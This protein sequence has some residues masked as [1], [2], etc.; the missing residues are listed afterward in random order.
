VQLKTILNRIEKQRFF[1]YGRMVLS[2]DKGR[3]V[4]DVD[5]LPRANSKPFCSGCMRRRPVYDHLEARRFEFVP[6]W[7]IAVFFIYVM[8]RVNCRTCGIIV[9]AVPWATGKRQITTSYAWFLARWAKR[10]SWLEVARTF[11]TTWEHVFRSVEMA[12]GWGRQHMNLDGIR[13]IGIDEI[14]WRK[15]HEYLTV[16]YQIDEGVRRLLWVGQK[17]TAK[18]LLRF[19][20]WF[21]KERTADLTFICSDMW[22]PYLKVIAK[23]ASQALNILDRFHIMS[24]MSKAIDEIRAGEARE[25]MRNGNALLKGSRWW[26]LKRPENLKA[27]QEASLREL[28]KYNLRAVRAYLLKEEFQLF[29]EYRSPHWANV[30]MDYWTRRVM[31]SRLE[32]MKKVARMLRRHQPLILNWFRAKGQLSSGAV[33]GLNN[34]AK[35]TTRKAYGFRNPAIAEVALYHA[36]G[37][38]PEPEYA[39]RFC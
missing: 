24:H 6:L 14:A 17:R 7:G 29:W 35:L 21:G 1:V 18:T 22:K 20:R 13:S 8:R 11:H 23:K 5:I 26:L 2:E 38:L 36:L 16:V 32:P 12:V 15:G 19:F 27:H 9:E 33:E 3:H 25:L 10:M 39:H 37:K 30:F 31:R 34:K 28:L 4:L